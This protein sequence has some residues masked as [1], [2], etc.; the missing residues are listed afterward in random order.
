MKKKQIK[1]YL[2]NGILLLGISLLLWNC[3]KSDLTVTVDSEVTK[4]LL[5][6]KS[7]KLSDIPDVKDFLN[8]KVKNKLSSKTGTLN[9]AIFD[10]DNILEVIDTLGNINYT[11][12]FTLPNSSLD[13]F[14]N[15]VVGKTP[16][17]ELKT[18]FVLKYTCDETSLDLYIDNNYNFSFFKGTISLHKYTDFFEQGYFSKTEATNCPPELDQNGDP[19]PCEIQPIDGSGSSSGEGVDGTGDNTT[20]GGS[21]PITSG[22]SSCQYVGV[23]VMGCG[24]TNSHRLH[25]LGSCGG[26][27]SIASYFSVWNCAMQKAS[28]TQVDCPPCSNLIEG[29]VGINTISLKSMRTTLKNKLTLNSSQIN[30]VNNSK[31][32]KEVTNIYNFLQ[33][34]NI[35]GN[36]AAGVTNFSKLAIDTYIDKSDFDLNTFN[37]FNQFIPDYKARMTQQ[38][39]SI[40]NSM[41][42]KLQTRYLYNANE[43]QN[44]AFELFPG[45]QRNTKADA[46]RHSYFHSLNTYF[47]GENLSIQLGDAHENETPNSL[48]LEK[49]MDLFNNQVGREKSKTPAIYFNA[50]GTIVVRIYNAIQNG[51]LK[52]LN[53]L[54]SDGTINSTTQLIPT[55]Q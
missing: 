50:Y 20:S 16:P 23:Y 7:V 15:L 24:G 11:F 53:P 2:K 18:P 39:L 22:G 8:L 40:F 17:G 46:F 49:V 45:V 33:T 31:N 4:S 30:W 52:Y 35:D 42:I 36:Y 14:Y 51:E 9:D 6:Q 48:I 1:T 13:T 27:K 43:A 12:R 32:D 26:D 29:G 44:K 34:Q 19:I 21:G 25:T 28:K 10:I 5:T 47:I 38:E 54:N 41:S 3:E 55:N 37:N